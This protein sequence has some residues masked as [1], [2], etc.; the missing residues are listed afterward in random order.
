V[1]CAALPIVAYDDYDHG[2]DDGLKRN[3]WRAANVAGEPAPR[4]PGEREEFEVTGWPEP[5]AGGRLRFAVA[6]WD[7]A[8]NRSPLSNLAEADGK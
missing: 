5:P 4:S 7:D 3:W 1:K 8:G 6:S 2:R